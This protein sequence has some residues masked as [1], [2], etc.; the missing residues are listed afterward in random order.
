MADCQKI[1]NFIFDKSYPIRLDLFL[2]SCLEKFSRS[3]IQSLIKNGAVLVDEKLAKP[4]MLIHYG[5]NIRIE[6]PPPKPIGIIAEPME[7]PIVYEDYSL[8]VVNK[9][10][11]LVV[12][13]APGHDSGTL[14]NGL[15]FHCKDLSGGGFIRPGIVHRLDKDTSGL[16]V[17]A[18][19][20]F[21]HAEISSQFKDGRVSKRY[22]CV[23]H[24]IPKSVSGEVNLPI[25]RH[26]EHRIKMSICKNGGRSARTIWETTE[27]LSDAF[28]ILSVRIVTGRTHQIRVHMSSIGHPIVGDITY[29]YSKGWWKKN[30]ILAKKEIS[31]PDRQLLHSTYLS[32]THPV[33]KKNM[34]FEV[35]IPIDMDNW[36]KHIKNKD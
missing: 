1:Y 16:M 15:L 28:S 5:A 4:S 12:H 31:P 6:I 17:V 18:K 22:I 9:P 8:L 11:G 29:G 30:L 14:V 7:I 3:Q 26:P 24:G 33:N 21:A 19:N 23:V 13:P 36:I 32:L 25:G 2:V 34:V 35:P 10:P 20:D 27:S